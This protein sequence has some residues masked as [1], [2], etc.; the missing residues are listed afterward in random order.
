MTNS[1]TDTI[2]AILLAIAMLTVGAILTMSL[3]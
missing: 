1:T 2:E 3:L